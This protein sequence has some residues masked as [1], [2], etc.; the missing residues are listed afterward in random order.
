MSHLY[1]VLFWFLCCYEYYYESLLEKNRQPLL[2]EHKQRHI[3]IFQRLAVSG[4]VFHPVLSEEPDFPASV[5]ELPWVM[6]V[7][8]EGSTVRAFP[9][10]SF[11]LESAI[12]NGTVY[13]LKSV[14]HFIMQQR[15]T[16]SGIQA[17][18]V[19][20]NHLQDLWGPKPLNLTGK[21]LKSLTSTL[22]R[23]QSR[24]MDF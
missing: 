16:E 14:L 4:G 19:K 24:W 23:M 2:S 11:H 18:R 5:C 12:R 9:F 3:C 8:V 6:A 20:W 17:V 21:P 7:C 22:Y 15:K 13:Y 10:F 1:Q